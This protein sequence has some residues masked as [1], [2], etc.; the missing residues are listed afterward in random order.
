MRNG[1]VVVQ[2]DTVQTPA[3]NSVAHST[4][5]SGLSATPLADAM[6]GSTAVIVSKSGL[7]W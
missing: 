1:A 6:F 2:V 4:L 5:P 3:Q 7:T